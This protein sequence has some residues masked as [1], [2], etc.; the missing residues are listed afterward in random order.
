VY[1]SRGLAMYDSLFTHS[2]DFK[3]YIFAFDSL[4][5]RMLKKLNLERVTVISLEEFETEELRK[6]K[7][8]RS[9]AEYCWTCTSS[10]IF[11]VLKNFDVSNCTYVDS[12]LFF[13][14]DPSVLISELDEYKKN[15]LMTEHR[16][17]FLPRLYEEKRAG[18]FCVQFL[19]FRNEESSLV[20]LDKWRKQCIEWCYARYEDGKFGDQKY[21]DEWPL[22][23]NNTHTLKHEGGGVAPWNLDNYRFY[24]EYGTI[25]GIV[26]KTGSEFNLVFYHFQYVKFMDNKFFDIGWYHISSF[27]EKLLYRPY[28]LKIEQIETMLVAVDTEYHKTVTIFRTDGIRNKLKTGFKKIFGYNIISI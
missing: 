19:T 17:S 10:T 9:K 21:L 8:E 28:L 20:V 13:F 2:S 14:S 11:Y 23:Y 3:L 5:E 22:I 12:D 27:I 7:K 6:V 15:V 18:R 1:L 16:F 26:R 25:K 4:T 24:R